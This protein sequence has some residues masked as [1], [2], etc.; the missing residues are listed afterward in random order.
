MGSE[1]CRVFLKD[2]Q[3]ISTLRPHQNPNFNRVK[4]KEA[5]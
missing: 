4:E 3:G 5:L 2:L 1:T